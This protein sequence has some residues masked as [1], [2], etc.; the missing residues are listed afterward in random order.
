[1]TIVR[2]VIITMTTA[3]TNC[4]PG[5]VLKTKQSLKSQ[6]PYETA[7]LICPFYRRGNRGTEQ[8]RCLTGAYHK[9]IL[10]SI[11]SSTSL[12]S[13]LSD[14]NPGSGLGGGGPVTWPFSSPATP[15]S[16]LAHWVSHPFQKKF[17]KND[18]HCV[19]TAIYFF[20]PHYKSNICS[21]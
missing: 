18:T 1:M 9:W 11:C 3:D 13:L 20:P 2:V 7:P 16:S 8:Q 17:W 10:N 15:T 21:L 14:S 6:Q 4:S 12:H 5:T 19:L